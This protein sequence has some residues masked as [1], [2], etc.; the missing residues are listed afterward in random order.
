MFPISSSFGPGSYVDEANAFGAQLGEQNHY[1]LMA[2]NTYGQGAPTN[3]DLFIRGTG[4]LPSAPLNLTAFGGN[5]TAILFWDRPLD[6]SLT[7][8]DEY[9]VFRAD[10]VGGPFHFVNNVNASIFGYVGLFFDSGLTN[11]TT[12]QY[13]VR[14]NNSHG[15]VGP[16]S[17]VVDVTPNG[18]DIPMQ[19]TTL[20]A[21]PGNNRILLIWSSAW[22]ATNYSV[23]RSE[24]SGTESLLTTLGD[25]DSYL[26]TTA[27]NGHTYFYKVKPMHH[28]TIGPFS[29][30]ASASASTGPV[31][32][33]PSLFATPSSDGVYLYS[34]SVTETNPI[35]GFHIWRNG[36]N[37]EN[38]STIQ[39]DSGFTMPDTSSVA[40]VNYDYTITA[41][42]LFGVSAASN[43][44]TSFMS[45][46]GDVPDPITS[47]GANGQP[48]GITV[49]WDSPTY[50]GTAILLYYEVYRN[51]SFGGWDLIGEKITTVGNVQWT[52]TLVIPGVTYTY[53]VL[54]YDLYGEA[55]A[56]SPG[57]S[58][59]AQSTSQVPSEPQ[60]LVAH[61]GA[62]YVLLEWQAPA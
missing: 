61:S 11:G 50:Q 48:G 21:Y 16:F 62:G 41:E 15:G 33:A 5:H 2:A 7:G 60:N 53:K 9:D 52:D 29:P 3:L 6:P 36:V 37:I 51:D 23:W 13:E 19:V 32:A 49:N 45:P 14:A 31:P 30:E 35:I 28:S 1:T 58:A 56:L 40:D 24:S 8:F 54:A 12:Y 17:N 20:N 38:V 57:A 39:F 26:D 22:N 46:T 10:T 47:I 43:V 25:V 27:T 4:A 34:P 59:A 42:N 44:A 18:V 55:S